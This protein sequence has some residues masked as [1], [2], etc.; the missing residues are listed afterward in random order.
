MS[1]TTAERQRKCRA[2]RQQDGDDRRL[3]TWISAQAYS[4]LER[5]SER[6]GTTKREVIEHLLITVDSDVSAISK[7]D[8]TEWDAYFETAGVTQ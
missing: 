3:N 1:K 2:R 8:S 7:I 5:L 4:A 6:C